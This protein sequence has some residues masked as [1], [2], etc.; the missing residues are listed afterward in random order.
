[1][2]RVLAR[3]AETLRDAGCAVSVFP[4]ARGSF[5]ARCRSFPGG[6]VLLSFLLPFTLQRWI[7]RCGITTLIVPTGPGGVFLLRRPKRCRLI[8][9]P[10][11]TYAQQARC[12]PGERW[13]LLL[14]APERRTYRMADTL[15]CISPDTKAAL[16]HEY[17][18][19]EGRIRVIPPLLHLD[20]WRPREPV[21]KEPG[22]CVFVGR[23][24]RRKGIDVLLAAWE[25]VLRERPDARL[26]IAGDGAMP[27]EELSVLVQRSDVALC[28]SYLEGFG[29]AA[30]EAMAAGTALIA[31]DAPGLRSLIRHGETGWLVPSGDPAAL[32]A[33]I[34][35]LLADLRRRE[36]L[37]GNAQQW[38]TRQFDP[39][40]SLDAL[41]SL[42][43]SEATGTG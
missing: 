9:N 12:V 22:L 3:M 26:V 14:A 37:A 39:A 27:E 10:H 41:R 21:I 18:I 35:E 25:S 2:G 31:C 38:I 20:C 23:R 32:A 30:D 16:V 17:G 33:A 13:K 5:L 29:L 28:P 8:A 36:Q 4:S 24:D 11:H 42:C 6:N 40:L 34:I 43:E 19:P 1:M 7:D 15:L